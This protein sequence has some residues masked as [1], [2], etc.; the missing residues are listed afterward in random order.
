LLDTDGPK[1]EIFPMTELI[2]LGAA[3]VS[4]A[5]TAAVHNKRRLVPVLTRMPK[6]QP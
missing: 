4:I 1:M 6:R 5:L 2:L 3:A